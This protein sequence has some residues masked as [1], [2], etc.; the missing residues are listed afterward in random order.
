MF[1]LPFFRFFR[2]WFLDCGRRRVGR[3]GEDMRQQTRHRDLK[4][5][6]RPDR[7]RERIAAPSGAS[8]LGDA[9]LGA[10]DGIVTTFAVVA[11]SAGGQLS[12]NVVIVLGFANLLA[13]GF[14]MAVS[15]YLSTRSRREEVEQAVQDEL[16]Q[17]DRYPLGEHR[18]VREI[19]ARKGFHGPTLDR[20]VD[21]ITRNREVW[22]DTMLEEELNLQRVAASPR[23]AALVT[24]LAFIVFGFIPLIP[25][26]FPVPAH[27]HLFLISGGLSAAAF[28]ILGVWKGVMLHR[29]PLRSGLQ[30]FLI[31]S[32]AALLAYGVGALLHTLFAVAPTNGA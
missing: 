12:T 22:I 15:N 27:R 19:F 10:T 5:E 16:W 9:V 31:G 6:H 7:V 25:F 4:E 8:A 18:E 17:I 24:F 28:A 2:L 1:F 23:R 20:I 30:T 14:S 11:G 29:P 21:V 3:A 32:I 13:D 26:V